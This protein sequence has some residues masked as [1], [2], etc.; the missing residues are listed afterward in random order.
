ME[1]TSYFKLILLIG[2]AL[3]LVMAFFLWLNSSGLFQNKILGT[4]NFLW[5]FVVFVFAMQSKDF[6]IKFPHLSR[7]VSLIPLTLFPLLYIYIRSYLVGKRWKFLNFTVHF[8][9]ALVYFM[10]ISPYYFQSAAAKRQMLI[11]DEL[12][13]YIFIVGKI[14][15]VII[16]L[17]GILYTTASMKLIQH[18]HNTTHRR[19]TRTQRYILDWLRFFVITYVFLWAIGTVGA[20]LEMLNIAV[21]FDLFNVFYLGLTI[22][23]I[24]IGV[25]AL[26]RPDI[27]QKTIQPSGTE[28]RFSSSDEERSSEEDLRELDLILNYLEKEK[29]YLKNDLSLAD[30]SEATDI[31]KHRISVLLN[32]ELGK[33]FYEIVNEYR[34]REAIRLMNEGKHLNFTLTYIAEMA[35]F[36]SK[37]TFNRIFKKITN[38]TPSEYIHTLYAKK[39]DRGKEDPKE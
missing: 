12:P 36:N 17:Q 5:F 19:L 9:P 24:S 14:F 13:G 7:I 15:D 31:P 3:A 10:A 4:M 11:S 30:I 39:Q 2:S 20:I 28:T 23:T 38:Q 18:F 8:L 27:L 26:R 37:A 33:S 21:P 22:L 34:T 32:N 35:G 16:I 6:Y 25:F 29:A 1:I